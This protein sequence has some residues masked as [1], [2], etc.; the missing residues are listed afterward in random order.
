MGKL[1]LTAGVVAL[2]LVFSATFGLATATPANAL[3]HEIIGAACRFGGEE[4]V[5]PGQAGESNGES[6]VRALQAT[7]VISSIV[8]T[9]TSVTVNFDLDKPSAKYESAGFTLVIPNGAGPGV[10]LI[11]NPLPVLD[12]TFPG[13]LHCANLN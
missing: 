5:P 12:G 2:S 7:G 1:R 11:L 10:A 8:E 13:H 3:I 6:F 4:V 9:P